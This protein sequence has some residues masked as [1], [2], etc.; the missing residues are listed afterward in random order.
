MMKEE[1]ISRSGYHMHCEGGVKGGDS[2]RHLM[3]G[4]VASVTQ[5]SVLGVAT[6]AE[7][8]LFVLRGLVLE[9]DGSKASAKLLVM[10]RVAPVAKWEFLR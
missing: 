8:E 5:G 4:R 9:R 1:S 10:S 6:H 3:Q 2:S 7:P